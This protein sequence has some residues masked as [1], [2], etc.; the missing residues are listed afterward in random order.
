M[1]KIANIV[2]FSSTK[3]F[4]ANYS[5]LKICIPYTT[6]K[7]LYKE[8]CKYWLSGTCFVKVWM[9]FD[10]TLSEIT[11]DYGVLKRWVAY[12]LKN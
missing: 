6:F 7:F 8:W 9:N 4:A 11:L 12:C 3:S 1:W 5:P 2:A 10:I